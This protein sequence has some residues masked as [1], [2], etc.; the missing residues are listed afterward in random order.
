MEKVILTVKPDK[1][2]LY[3]AIFFLLEALGFLA[4]SGF[5]FETLSEDGGVMTFFVLG[6]IAAVVSAGLMLYYFLEQ[7]VFYENGEIVYRDMLGGK[8][9]LHKND[10]QKI[11]ITKKH[12]ADQWITLFGKNKKELARISGSMKSY[13]EV[14]PIVREYHVPI[15]YWTYGGKYSIPRIQKR[16]WDNKSGE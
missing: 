2:N 1:I 6:L 10:V 16:T 13:E 4:L 3:L 8:K 5:L 12:S 7:T 15:E 11:R 9:Y 14:Y